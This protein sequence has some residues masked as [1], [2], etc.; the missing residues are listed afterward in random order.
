MQWLAYPRIGLFVVVCLSASSAFAGD[1][2][3]QAELVELGR[4]LFFEP[5]V[6]RSGRF[7]CAACHKP[8]HGF[9]DPRVIS[10][11]HD[12]PMRRHSQP[13]TDLVDGSGMHWDGE[14]ETVRDLIEARLV[15]GRVSTFSVHRN[16]K[17]I[18]EAAK[19]GGN[20]PSLKDFKKAKAKLP[21]PITMGNMGTSA[22]ASP[23]AP[24]AER[25]MLLGYYSEAFEETFGTE[26]PNIKQIADAVEA[27]VHS[28]QTNT[29]ALDRYLT[30]DP[31]ALTSAQRRGYALFSGKANCAEC[32][33]PKLESGRAAM[34]DRSYRSN[35]VAYPGLLIVGG[36]QKGGDGG[37]GELTHVGKDLGCFKVPSLR[38]VSRRAP[39]MHDGSLATLEDVVAFYARGGRRGS[40]PTGV[41]SVELNDDEKKDLVTFLKAL[42]APTRAGVGPA[43]SKP[44]RTRL[45][46]EDVM[47]RPMTKF[48]VRVLPAGDRLGARSR[49][50]T[51]LLVTDKRGIVEFTFPDWTHVR[52]EAGGY[53]VA[54]GMPIPDSVRKLKL[55]AVPMHKRYVEVLLAPSVPREITA[56]AL[57]G[58]AGT[59]AVLRRVRRL[60]GTRA[61][62]EV[63][64]VPRNQQGK[65]VLVRLSNDPRPR[66]A[67]ELDLSRGEASPIHVPSRALGEDQ[68]R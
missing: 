26:R 9:S 28:L 11:E 39:Y 6:S 18:F 21:P 58:S 32:H 38:D 31:A 5:A 48:A 66:G 35:G 3:S 40:L 63:T 64:D 19:L 34:T 7:E 23:F 53:E 62:Y 65:R 60:G 41:K 68:Y 8:E 46:I 24:I 33:T 44:V 49:D 29:N 47:G 1:D 25:L 14:F 36:Q 4:R 15:P 20:K 56:V 13:L 17:R 50:D 55:R 61:L 16:R 45:V 54:R 52:V 27:Y 57:S 2:P 67:V 22:T 42:T 12:G 37:R 30:G 10:E 43:R 51:L 59:V